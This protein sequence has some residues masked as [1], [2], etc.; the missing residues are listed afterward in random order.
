MKNKILV[1]GGAGFIG[2]NATRFFLKKKFDVIIFDNFSRKGTKTNLKLLEKEKKYFNKFKFILG[3]IRNFKSIS[4]VIKKEK[5]NLILHLAGQVAVTS[6]IKDPRND[7]ENN[8]N[9]TFNILE[10]CRL[11]SDKS[12]IIYSSTNKV[13]GKINYPMKKVKNRWVFKS[14]KIKNGID[15]NQSLEFYS[16]YGCSKGAADQYVLDYSRIYGLNTSVVRQSCIYGENQ[17]G[18]EDQGWISWFIIAFLL[19]KEITIYGDGCQVRDIL[20][21]DDLSELYLKIFRNKRKTK[22]HVFNAGG[23][24]KNSISIIDLIN[25]LKKNKKLNLR[26]KFDKERQGDQKIFISN[27]SKLFKMIKW[28]PKIFYKEGL[29]KIFKWTANNLDIIKSNIR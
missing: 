24:L 8:I 22:G 15:E 27:N 23:G 12:F 28:R 21:V 11:Y 17:F 7:L 1:I 18:I 29:N 4:K 6:S 16:P 20:F 5:P 9:G 13:Y 2:I 3:D 19:K 10:S 26:Y 25:F 14:K